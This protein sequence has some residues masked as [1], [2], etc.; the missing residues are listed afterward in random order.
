MAGET[1]EVV[2][3]ESNFEAGFDSGS[4]E[5]PTEETK[6]AAEEAPKEEAAPEPKYAQ[7]TE[8]QYQDLMAKAASVDKAFGKI[9]GIERTLATLQTPS[10]QSIEV[11]ADDFAELREEFPEL[12]ELQAKGLNKVL[13]KLKGPASDPAAI[14][15]LVGDR[16]ADVRKQLIDA[17]LD[18]IVDGDWVTEFNSPECQT[19][20]NSQPENVQALAASDSARDAAR[21]LRM[22][23]AS[24][25]KP[26]PEPKPEPSTR[27]QQLEAAIPPKGTGGHPSSPKENAFAAGFE[28]GRV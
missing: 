25:A 12:A 5:T 3:T 27:K 13:G 8:A 18:A 10:G 14:D 24:K 26:K 2:K 17:S 19:W 20:M 16:V 6:P 11:S 23:Q 21:F 28:S 7:I 1:E 15:K 9:G 22:Y 4:T